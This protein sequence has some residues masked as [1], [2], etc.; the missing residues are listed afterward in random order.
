MQFKAI[1]KFEIKKQSTISCIKLSTENEFCAIG[2]NNGHILLYA[3]KNASEP[4]L[5]RELH[6][7]GASVNALLFSPWTS[8][9][10]I[11]VILVSISIELCF[12]NVS[13]AVNNPTFAN[14][15]KT[16]RS[17]RFN[18][19]HI[20][21]GITNSYVTSSSNGFND[22]NSSKSL[23]NGEKMAVN[24]WIGKL[25]ASTKPELLACIKFVGN[26]AKR[27]YATQEFTTFLTIDDEGEIYFLRLCDLNIENEKPVSEHLIS[28]SSDV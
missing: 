2:C 16:R 12:W 24:P 7:H 8:R 13:F 5:L 10:N 20:G 17:L 1:G 11:P 19:K 28:S 3:M 14:G 4:Q 6:S 9:S 26:A 25:G 18:D 21:N 15:I 23:N 27:V 22:L